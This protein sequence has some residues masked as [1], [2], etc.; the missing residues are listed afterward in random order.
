[1]AD[2]DE[3]AKNVESVELV[4]AIYPQ[5]GTELVVVLDVLELSTRILTNCK[6]IAMSFA[7][8]P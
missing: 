4:S 1:M 2:L 7:Q 5:A 3:V 8:L 6:G